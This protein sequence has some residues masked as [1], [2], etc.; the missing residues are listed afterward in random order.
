M[1][2]WKNRKYLKESDREQTLEPGMNLMD[3]SGTSAHLAAMMKFL[4]LGHIV[5]NHS[6]LHS[7]RSS[8]SQDDG[9]GKSQCLVR[10]PSVCPHIAEAQGRPAQP[11]L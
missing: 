9:A 6:A 8:E 10:I 4:G 5:N 11:L 2:C 7:F 1:L 3:F